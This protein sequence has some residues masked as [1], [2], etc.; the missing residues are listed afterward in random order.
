MVAH[1]HSTQARETASLREQAE[2]SAEHLRELEL[3]LA[4]LSRGSAQAPRARSQ[5]QPFPQVASLVQ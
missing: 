3:R 5:T 4:Q 2:D 1:R